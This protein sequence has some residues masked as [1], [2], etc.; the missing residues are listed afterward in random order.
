VVGA[1]ARQVD[2]L[3]HALRLAAFL[4][5]PLIERQ[6]REIAMLARQGQAHQH[7]VADE[8]DATR[9]AR[10]MRDGIEPPGTEFDLAHFAGPGIADV[11]TSAMQTG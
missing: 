9:K 11:Q 3:H 1:A 7:L 8:R 6:A 10:T 4:L 2:H 5:H